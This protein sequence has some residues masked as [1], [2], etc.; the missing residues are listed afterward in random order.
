MG[1]RSGI[2]G[3][4]IR[5][6]SQSVREAAA[7]ERQ[8][9]AAERRMEQLRAARARAE[10]AEIRAR[11]AEDVR[12]A[13]SEVREAKSAERARAL[14]EK[15]AEREAHQ[16]LQDD[17]ENQTQEIAEFVNELSSIL[18][19]T[20][21]IDDRIDF[22]SLRIHGPAPTFT[23]PSLTLP[24]YVPPTLMPDPAGPP[25]LAN[26]LAE[27]VKPLTW[28]ERLVRT[29]RR[30]ERDVAAATANH[31]AESELARAERQRLK[32]LRD[33]HR[34]DFDQRIQ[35]VTVDHQRKVDKLREVHAAAVRA[36]EQKQSQRNAEVDA[37]VSGYTQADAESVTLYN[38]MVLE[39]SNYPAGFPQL[40]RLAYDPSSKQL[41]IDYE[42][43]T[44]EIV[45]AVG[46]YRYVKAR[47]AVDT[48]P[49][50]PTE[51]KSL[52]RSIVAQTALRTIH[53]VLEA[54]Q[55][56]HIDVVVF[57]GFINKVDESTGID[58][59]PYLIS[60]R[61]TKDTFVA[62]NL[63]RVEPQIC[64]KNLGA[65]VS[66]S[67]EEACAVRPIIE[68]DMVDPRF[69]D[70]SNVLDSLESRPN[71]MDL[72]PGEF[73]VLVSNLFSQLGLETKLTRS[74][75]DGGVDAVAFD[76]RP[77]LGGKV[78]IQAKRY[79]NTVGV[80]AVRD[81]YGTMLNEGAS[82]G[83]LVTT[84]KYGPD[85]FRFA[86]DKPMELIDGGGLLYLLESIGRP[87]R[88]IMP[89]ENN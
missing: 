29:R 52:Y 7:R 75:R 12:V 43:P 21:D 14:A 83:I 24:A 13:R 70:Q 22:E 57:S 88:I 85:A 15:E 30:Y 54:D 67:P 53:E 60:V 78:V 76:T 77:I 55:G 18:A 79:K 33:A 37:L 45:P 6:H 44:V 11:E 4:L 72:T 66:P 25:L 16:L 46:E 47:K 34:R 56:N 68:F 41:V 51:I 10:A 73:E 71:L 48:K 69:I 27:K 80:S 84:S 9:A 28:I 49:R 82:K 17:A 39:R 20:L 38:E 31:A 1:R 89:I 3:V 26:Y 50:K 63:A 19:Y 81:L 42:L 86:D 59:R 32:S 87:A 8:A 62:I 58:I 64:L 74:S 40:F 2:V 23:A 5:A 61:T 35:A 65:Q 36:F